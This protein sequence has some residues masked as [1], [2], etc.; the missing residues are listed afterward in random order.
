MSKTPPPPGGEG[1]V[2]LTVPN[3]NDEADGAEQPPKNEGAP[4]ADAA[5]A[6]A[7]AASSRSDASDA[8]SSVGGS[9]VVGCDELGVSASVRVGSLLW[10]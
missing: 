3:P 8:P 2:S 10:G 6:V 5:A 1:G 7:A 4:K 9:G